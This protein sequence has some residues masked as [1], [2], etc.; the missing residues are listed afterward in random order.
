MFCSSTKIICSNLKLY[1]NI[2]RSSLF[3]KSKC[4]SE[5][6]QRG[7][8]TLNNNCSSPFSC[9][10]TCHCNTLS[11][12]LGH[13]DC[14]KKLAH[15][16]APVQSCANYPSINTGTTSLHTNVSYQLFYQLNSF[17]ILFSK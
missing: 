16:L 9:D 12:N 10:F 1:F 6:I 4:S 7:I 8:I 11:D 15:H 3:S 2:Y 14:N 13:I 5:L 17:S